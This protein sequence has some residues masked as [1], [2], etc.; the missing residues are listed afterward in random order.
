MK[1]NGELKK[2]IIAH[3]EDALSELYMDGPHRN[4]ID[5]IHDG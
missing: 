2:S 3:E 5:F 4:Y 1:I